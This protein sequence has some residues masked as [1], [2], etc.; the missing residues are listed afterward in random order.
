MVVHLETSNLQHEAFLLEKER[1]KAKS[2]RMIQQV[3]QSEPEKRARGDRAGGEKNRAQ[4]LP[5]D[6]RKGRNQVGTPRPEQRGTNA[7][8]GQRGQHV[9]E[10]R[11]AHTGW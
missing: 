7:R 9:L 11:K 10:R 4:H 1:E 5:K 2:K 8:A 6:D 3:R